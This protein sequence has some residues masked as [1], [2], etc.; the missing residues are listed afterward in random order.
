VKDIYHGAATS[1][2]Q[3]LTAVGNTLFFLADDGVHGL[4]LWKSNGTS[5]GTALVKEFAPGA[6]SPSFGLRGPTLTAFNGRLYFEVNGELWQSNGTPAGT[7]RVAP[8]TLV[9]DVASLN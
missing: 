3:A 4:E 5:T 1:R 9:T 7:A 2:P 8:N 6:D